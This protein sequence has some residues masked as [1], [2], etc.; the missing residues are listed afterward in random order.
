MIFNLTRSVPDAEPTEPTMYLYGHEATADE[1][2]DVILDG[3]GYV[4]AVLPKLP[5]ERADYK[6][7]FVSWGL[8]CKYLF[9][10]NEE[11]MIGLIDGETKGLVGKEWTLHYISY[12]YNPDVSDSWAL[13]IENGYTETAGLISPFWSSHDLYNSD[14]TL[15][16]T[17]SEPVPVYE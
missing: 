8:G 11:C 1:T 15:Y 2:A 17:G 9:L 14:G 16:L 5:K 4:G 7:A 13:S 6:Y 3:V 12:E 10:T